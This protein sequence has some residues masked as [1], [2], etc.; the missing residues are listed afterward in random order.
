LTRYTYESFDEHVEPLEFVSI[1][2]VPFLKCRF[3]PRIAV[4][5]ETRERL[6]P[7]QSCV[8]DIVRS[9]TRLIGKG[10]TH[11][12]IDWRWSFSLAE[13]QL[14]RLWT[15]DQFFIYNVF[16]NIFYRFINP[17]EPT[18]DAQQN[19][20]TS[21]L[22]K[23]IMFWTCEQSP[24]SFWEE[25]NHGDSLTKLLTSLMSALESRR[26]E[27]YF[28]SFNLLEGIADQLADQAV[29]ILCSLLRDPQSIIDQIEPNLQLV[30]KILSNRASCSMTQT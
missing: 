8:E 21:Y 10:K 17:L 16:K 30:E 14:T 20:L 7:D 28:I 12:S 1:D 6:W 27:H 24:P 29:K 23:T 26:L 4:E 18:D 5:W 2:I 9:S 19:Y 3:W 22:V 15:I 11:R 25:S 13:L